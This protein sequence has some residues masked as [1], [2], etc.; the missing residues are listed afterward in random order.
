MHSVILCAIGFC[1]A[2]FSQST[3][4]DQYVAT[5]SPIAKAGLLANIGPSGSKSSG[6]AVRILRNDYMLLYA[7]VVLKAGVVIASPS[8]TNPDYLFTWVRD[9]SLVFKVIIDQ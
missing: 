8:T 9:S 2:V 6:A 7:D 1:A 5:E 4:V 3:V